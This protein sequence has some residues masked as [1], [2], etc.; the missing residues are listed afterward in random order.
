M[1]WLVIQLDGLLADTYTKEVSL[2]SVAGERL[3]MMT[4]ENENKASIEEKC[5]AL[6]E[7]KQEKTPC[8]GQ[9]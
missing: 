7:T 2:C 8:S 9:M 5:Q 1:K 4:K 3:L 6:R